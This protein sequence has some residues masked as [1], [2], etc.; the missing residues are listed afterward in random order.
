MW[1]LIH[2]IHDSSFTI[3]PILALIV[4]LSGSLHCMGMCGGLVYA[5]AQD[6]KGHAFYHLGRLLSY[7]I[8]MTLLSFMGKALLQTQVF[9]W[10]FHFAAIFFFITFIGLGLRLWKSRNIDALAPAFMGRIYERV[11]GGLN[12]KGIPLSSFILGSLSIFLPCGLLY[13]LFFALLG[14]KN[15]GIAYLSII[16]FWS[17]TLP[18]FILGK[19]LLAKVFSV[20]GS[21]S[22][23]LMGTLLIVIGLTGLSLRIHSGP[24]VLGALQKERPL[25]E[26]PS[27][28]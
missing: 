20:F 6:K 22:P 1:D 27:C 9:P 12:R 4:G 18:V 24:E 10:F 28:H 19:Q 25:A 21:R 11:T 2:Q 5:I 16:L 17:G 15:L 13:T 8:L 7:L 14:I 26:P 23:Q 3:V